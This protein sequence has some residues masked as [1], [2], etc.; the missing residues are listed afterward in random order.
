MQRLT[1]RLILKTFLLPSGPMLPSRS[2]SIDEPL[3]TGGVGRVDGPAIDGPA[4]GGPA[5]EYGWE[6]G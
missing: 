5:L 3:L 6:L 4:I 1:S 2:R